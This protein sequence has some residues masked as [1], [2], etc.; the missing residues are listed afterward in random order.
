MMMIDYDDCDDSGDDKCCQ[1]SLFFLRLRK[2]T[3]FIMLNSVEMLELVFVFF[4]F[5]V[6]FL[7]VCVLTVWRLASI[8][9]Q[10]VLTFFR[11]LFPF[12][13]I[14]VLFLSLYRFG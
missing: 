12:T 4:V 1:L 9:T 8:I 2:I 7:F 14:S 11:C 3:N 5:F 6:C 13:I 10:P